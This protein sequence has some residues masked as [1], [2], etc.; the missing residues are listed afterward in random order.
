MAV[1]TAAEPGSKHNVQRARQA[2]YDK[3]SK[4]HMAPLWEVLKDLV[5]P[6]P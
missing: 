2:Y 3:F 4:Y 6:E 5:T 1:A